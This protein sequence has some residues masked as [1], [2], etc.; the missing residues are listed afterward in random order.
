MSIPSCLAS[1]QAQYK[2]FERTLFPDKFNYALTRGVTDRILSGV[3]TL[4]R[5]LFMVIVLVTVYVIVVGAH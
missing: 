2:L 4:F 5:T 1:L 3:W